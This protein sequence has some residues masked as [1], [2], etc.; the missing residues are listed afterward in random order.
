MTRSF[1]AW[2]LHTKQ[3]F[4]CDQCGR[5]YKH[6]TN[7]C[8][9]KR[10]ECGKPPSHFCPLC[11]KG[12]KKKQH[13]QRHLTVHNDV[14]LASQDPDSDVMKQLMPYLMRQDS[15]K[16]ESM[17]NF[18]VLPKVENAF[19]RTSN[20]QPLSTFPKNVFQLPGMPYSSP[21]YYFPLPPTQSSTHSSI[22]EVNNDSGTSEALQ[23]SDQTSESTSLIIE[24][25]APIQ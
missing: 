6:R 8:N 16:L 17:P 9:H 4:T 5:S 13:L 3:R 21:M 25:Y 7:L 20:F 19:A 24:N 2:Q 22:A 15:V 23:S 14:D 10:E 11:K 12:F 1:L 18:N